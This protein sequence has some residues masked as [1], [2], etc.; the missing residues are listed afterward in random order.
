MS[1]EECEGALGVGSIS[2]LVFVG[3]SE[4]IPRQLA[5]CVLSSTAIC[6][7]GVQL[8]R[9]MLLFS[10]FVVFWGPAGIMHSFVKKRKHR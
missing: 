8:P 9:K 1:G 3:P 10:V 7:A 4:K 5:V 6:L 2:T